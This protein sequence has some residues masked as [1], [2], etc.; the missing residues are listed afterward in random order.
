MVVLKFGGTSVGTAQA[1]RRVTAIV[2]RERRPRVV[3]VSA[4]AGVTDALLAMAGQIEAGR[5]DAALRAVDD[6]RGRHA[7]AASAVRGAG[8]RAA[9]LAEID[10]DIDVLRALLRALSVP[11]EVPP[12]ALDAIAATGELLSS[13]LAAARWRRPAFP[14]AGWMPG[15]RSSRTTITRGPRRSGTARRSGS[16]SWPVRNWRQDACR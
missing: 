10:R 5:G 8:A 6:L 12:R 16:S 11:Q 4:L 2:S 14:A 9:V 1:L 13:R 3:V 7:E 15:R